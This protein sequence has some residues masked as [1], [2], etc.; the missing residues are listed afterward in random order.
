[1]KREAKTLYLES[2]KLK[3]YKSI[4]DVE[5]DFLPG[6]N[7]LIGRN[8]SGKTNLLTLL[9]KIIS[10]EF[11]NLSELDGKIKLYGNERF[12]MNFNKSPH[13]IEENASASEFN[14]RIEFNTNFRISS[15][16]KLVSKGVIEQNTTISEFM[17]NKI[18]ALYIKHG[19]PE[20]YPF[21]GQNVNFELKYSDYTKYLY[22]YAINRN[23]PLFSRCLYADFY[24][25][26]FV[27][28]S[29]VSED[30]LIDRITNYIE[31]SK[32]YLVISLSSI[33]NTYTSV[34]EV[35]IDSKCSTTVSSDGMKVEGFRIE[36]K[37]DG[38]W[39]A[40]E[41]LSDGTKRIV[42]MIMEMSIDNIFRVN[43]VFNDRYFGARSKISEKAISRVVFLEEPE[44]GVHPKQFHSIMKFV[45]RFAETN[46]IIMSTHAPQALDYITLE[47]LD[48]IIIASFDKDKG[49]IF[50][51]MS[52]KQKR[53]A[54]SYVDDAYLRD[55]WIHS[56]LEI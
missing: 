12:D 37:I 14:S 13:I 38:T 28:K 56:T 4:V 48:R 26:F 16:R 32:S 20:E 24:S 7:I 1:M 17:T 10:L 19:Y 8:G 23:I 50:K 34:Q 41:D 45:E 52:D 47:E 29:N 5:I 3:G 42:Y 21:V 35:R 49:S 30:S 27:G 55:M 31:K 22:D 25:A 53:K 18:S 39:H 54:K 36:F 33:M 51:R 2:A 40:F 44:L 6:L 43:Y 46:Q 11:D 9:S 15:G